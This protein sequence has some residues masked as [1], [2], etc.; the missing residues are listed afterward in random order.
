MTVAF[1]PSAVFRS[2]LVI[3]IAIVRG[4]VK[5]SLSINFT[6]IRFAAIFLTAVLLLTC[7]SAIFVLVLVL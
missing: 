2:K 5:P 4:H 7:V 1:H 3:L 6:A